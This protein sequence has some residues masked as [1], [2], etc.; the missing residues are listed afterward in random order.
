MFETCDEDCSRPRWWQETLPTI[1][2]SSDRLELLTFDDVTDS[3]SQ[4]LD[5]GLAL[6][7]G[8]IFAQGRAM[9]A[10]AVFL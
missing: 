9:T 5:H 8:Y 2:S 1:R 3:L 6:W 10:S 4:D 7:P